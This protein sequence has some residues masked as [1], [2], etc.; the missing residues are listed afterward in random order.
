MPVISYHF[1]VLWF[2][3]FSATAF[4]GWIAESAYR[5]VAEHRAVNSGFLSGPFIPIYGFGAP[6]IAVLS[7]VI[8]RESVVIYWACL[9]L[10]PSFV[11]FMTSWLFERLFGLRLWDYSKEPFNF[12]GRI[13]LLYSSFWIALT[14]MSVLW[15]E[16]FL[17]GAISSIGD[18]ARYYLAGALSMYFLIDTVHSSSAIMYFKLFLA[19]LRELAARGGS[20]LPSLTSGNGRLPHEIRRVLKP[21]KA[22][23]HLVRELKP[24]IPVIPEW[25]A[26]KMESIIGDRNFRK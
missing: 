11:E 26:A 14:V 3:Y 16:P 10:T 20:F 15:L 22:F 6:A 12:K 13:C 21:L 19:T 1:I 25:I 17:L 24:T 23:P 7:R 18:H 2:L 9:A 8:P 5:S 4:M